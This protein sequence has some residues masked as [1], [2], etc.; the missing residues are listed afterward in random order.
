MKETTS[1]FYTGLYTILYLYMCIIFHQDMKYCF[2]KHLTNQKLKTEP[3]YQHINRT[4]D[5]CVQKRTEQSFLY[6]TIY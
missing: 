2:R 5:Q 3:A 4:L 6:I 1:L